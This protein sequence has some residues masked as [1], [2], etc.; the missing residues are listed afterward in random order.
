MG[1]NKSTRFFW[2]STGDLRFLTAINGRSWRGTTTHRGQADPKA[3]NIQCFVNVPEMLMEV[4]FSLN[5]FNL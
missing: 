4:V 1:E 3:V 5:N 2:G